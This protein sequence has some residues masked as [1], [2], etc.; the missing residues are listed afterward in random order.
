MMIPD[1]SAP[2]IN[3]SIGRCAAGRKLTFDSSSV[4]ASESRGFWIDPS[5]LSFMLAN[6]QTAADPR[7][8][9][10]FLRAADA[11][12]G[13]LLGS[14]CVVGTPKPFSPDGVSVDLTSSVTLTGGLQ[15]VISFHAPVQTAV[16]ILERMTGLEADGV[17]DC[18]LD[19]M[20]EMANMIGGHGKRELEHLTLQLGLPRVVTGVDGE[21]LLPDWQEHFWVTLYTDLGPCAMGIA[22]SLPQ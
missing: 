8:A 2:D 1:G 22:W 7:I 10:P 13:T 20:G 12:F 18:V 15:G 21:L 11:V 9:G 5:R 14:P 4:H 3:V 16:Q 17:D 19:A 6:A